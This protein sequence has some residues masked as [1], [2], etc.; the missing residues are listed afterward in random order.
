MLDDEFLPSLL[1]THEL[2][3]AAQMIILLYAWW[4]HTRK[5]GD[6]HIGIY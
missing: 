6:R 4:M 1:S 3:Q 2:K 5:L